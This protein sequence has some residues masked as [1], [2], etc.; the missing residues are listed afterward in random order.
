MDSNKEEVLAICS[1]FSEEYGFDIE[2]L[3]TLVVY[4]KSEYLN[5]LSKMLDKKKY[6]L[7]SYQVYGDEV[8]VYYIS[9]N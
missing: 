5:E 2:D 6:K 8:L 9:K 1:E 3:E 4:M 7:Y